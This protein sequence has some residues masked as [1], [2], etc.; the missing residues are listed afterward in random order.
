MGTH[1]IFESDFDCLTE[2]MAKGVSNDEKLAR[3]R[4][5]L[6]KSKSFHN[7][8]DLEKIMCKQIGISPMICADIIQQLLDENLIQQERVGASNFY[9]CFE[10]KVASDLAIRKEQTDKELASVQ[11]ELEAINASGSDELMIDIDETKEPITKLEKEVSKMRKQANSEEEMT[12]E[13]VDKLKQIE[14]DAVQEINKWTDN[15]FALISW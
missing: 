11:A 8:N 10:S 4:A 5:W 14:K 13:F 15:I 7:K 6:I 9:W 1:P 12:V 2:K 3:A